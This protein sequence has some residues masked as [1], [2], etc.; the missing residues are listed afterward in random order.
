M[1]EA[2]QPFLPD[3]ASKHVESLLK[4]H[5]FKLK[6][7]RPRKTKLGD[8]R[9]GIGGRSHQI[10]VNGDLN[11]YHFLLTLV[12]EIAHMKT[13]EEYRVR[14]APHGKE[15]K[16]TFQK[17]MAPIL[18]D[19]VYPEHLEAPIRKYLSNPKA[20]CSADTDL[21][22]VL[23]GEN[24]DSNSV[25]TLESL[26]ENAIFQ[27]PGR[28]PMRKGMKRRTRFLCEELKTGRNFAVH[29]LAEVKRLETQS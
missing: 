7:V 10:T 29:P 19:S 15:W 17:A 5:S 18:E 28:S 22:R 9:P 2:L 6:V 26:P 8:F 12:H 3:G 1:I 20:S 11:P 25:V 23:R 13:H 4:P 16:R 14:V 24:S 27:L 21:L